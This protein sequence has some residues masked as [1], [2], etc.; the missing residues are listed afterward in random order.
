MHHDAYP[1]PPPWSGSLLAE[2]EKAFATTGAD[3]PGWPNPR[4]DM[5]PPAD[6]EYSRCLDP[7]KYRILDARVAAW[8]QV[9][10]GRVLAGTSDLPAASAAT[11]IGAFRD[12]EGLLRVQEIR[13]VRPRGLALLLATTLVDGEPFGLDIAVAGDTA[14]PVLIDAMP[15]CG[16]D[17][18]DDGSASLLD[19]LD[20][21]FVVVATGGVVHARDGKRSIT[22][23]ADGW[24]GTG[25][26]LDEAWLRAE[27]PVP[28]GMRRWIGA[29]WL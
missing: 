13:P 2:V 25:D 19:D 24:Q 9:L 17:A 28:P 11:W 20:G 27:T 15:S 7:G 26:D 23:T 6:E 4:P 18:C 14:A 12:V 8:A 16:C 22:R 10:A 1:S 21:W 5:E 29:P 3:T